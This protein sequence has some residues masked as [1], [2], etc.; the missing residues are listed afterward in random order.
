MRPSSILFLV[1]NV[2][3]YL[4]LLL[5]V[6]IVV[7]ISFSGTDSVAFPP[8]SFSFRWFVRFL[9]EDQL[10]RALLVSCGLA[11]A[12]SIISLT[13]GGI[14]AFAIARGTFWGR[15]AILNFLMTPLMVPALVIAMALL[16]FFAFLGTPSILGL[17]IGHVIITLPYVMRTMV[18]GLTGADMLAEQAA[19][20]L[21]CTPLQAIRLVTIPML[22]NSMVAS[23]LFSFII[24]FENLPLSLFL[25]DPDTVTLPM[26]IYNYIQWV[27]DPT[28]AAAATINFLVV[29]L[30]VF[31]AERTIGLSRF[32]GVMK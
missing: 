31:V 30:L 32:M 12:S 18:A 28:V 20:S 22:T 13:F 23:V 2:A 6:I 14:A 29:V 16:E 19:I 21:G 9:G 10:V 24:S 4:F 25:S 3:I 26:Q 17:L 11:V 1:A 15:S 27:F 7:A 5:P 8:T